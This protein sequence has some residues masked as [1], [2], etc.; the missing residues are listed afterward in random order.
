METLRENDPLMWT[1]E[2]QTFQGILNDV[3]KATNKSHRKFFQTIHAR[4][5]VTRTQDWVKTIQLKLSYE[6]ERRIAHRND[7][8]SLLTGY[9]VERRSILRS[10]RHSSDAHPKK[11]HDLSQKM[12]EQ[13]KRL[14]G[15][16][17]TINEVEDM[18]KM[19]RIAMK[20]IAYR[21]KYSFKSKKNLPRVLLK[22]RPCGTCT[23]G[24]EQKFNEGILPNLYFQRA[25][26][27]RGR[28]RS[29]RTLLKTQ[30]QRR[31]DQLTFLPGPH[32]INLF[33]RI[34]P[35]SPKAVPL[36][37]KIAQSNLPQGPTNEFHKFTSLPLELRRMIWK[38]ALP[39]G[40]HV[41]ADDWE[42]GL[43]HLL[44]SPK[45]SDSKNSL[46]LVCKESHEVVQERYTF[47][48]QPISNGAAAQYPEKITALN[49]L[50]FNPD[51]D[52]ANIY[53]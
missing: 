19:A 8:I 14:V 27:D 38:A 33:K 12:V 17:R 9:Y 30:R 3:K 40:R 1:K 22:S 41:F 15:N 32:A 49:L 31:K 6:Q 24:R 52:I 23:R 45:A 20:N 50:P 16:E 39:E 48:F 35:H 28:S 7:E 37:Q 10:Q 51:K 36:D 2:A 47:V 26:S 13:H 29:Q 18:E 34:R 11:M 43:C 53:L 4:D 46:Q 21:A 5:I 25:L 42:L 44:P